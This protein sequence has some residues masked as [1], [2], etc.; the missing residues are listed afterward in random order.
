[1][2]SSSDGR[3]SGLVEFTTTI[4]RVPVTRR[5]MGTGLGKMFITASFHARFNE[6]LFVSIALTL[7][8]ISV[9]LES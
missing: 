8:V 2:E 7:M 5:E 6:L 1:M 4:S 9:N 3:H